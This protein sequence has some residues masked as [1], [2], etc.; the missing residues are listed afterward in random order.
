MLEATDRTVKMAGVSPGELD[1][2]LTALYQLGVPREL[3]EDQDR[4]LGLLSMADRYEVIALRDACAV[5][6]SRQLTEDNM[7]AILRVADLHQA[8]GLRLAALDFI[9]AR[10]ER[11][12]FAMDS[13]DQSV[14]RSVR[15]H[16]S[17]LATSRE[18]AALRPI[19]VTLTVWP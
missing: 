9:T 14:R 2:F 16:L 11:V 4:L 18:A 1:D 6:L 13:D 15:E 5:L 10:M 19:E 3:Q 12:A 8:E 7:V 17:A